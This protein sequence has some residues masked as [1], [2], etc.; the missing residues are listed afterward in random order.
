VHHLERS[1]EGAAYH[2]KTVS[3]ARNR[4]RAVVEQRRKR[5]TEIGCGAEAIQ[6]ECLTYEAA[7]DQK[8][9]E[10]LYANKMLG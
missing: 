10:I 7:L 4:L 2:S 6:A 5:L 9:F 8:M 3:A 1:A